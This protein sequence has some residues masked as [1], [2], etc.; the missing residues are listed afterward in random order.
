ML[1]RRARLW[2]VKAEQSGKI[3]IFCVI[4]HS[5][6]LTLRPLMIKLTAAPIR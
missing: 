1:R 2:F 4:L 5:G 3:A 6:H